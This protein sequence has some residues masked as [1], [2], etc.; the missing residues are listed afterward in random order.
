MFYEVLCTIL[1]FTIYNRLMVWFQ[2]ILCECVCEGWAFQD[3]ASQEE[4]SLANFYLPSFS[5]HPLRIE[6]HIF[7]RNPSR[8]LLGGMIKCWE[9]SLLLTL[10]AFVSYIT[11][12]VCLIW[13]VFWLGC[14]VK[15]W[16]WN[17][18]IKLGTGVCRNADWV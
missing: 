5:G 4:V 15:L 6:V 16:T 11:F 10:S 13:L 8:I 2:P 9:R 1:K 14:C 17:W 7:K 3:Q 18:N 12:L